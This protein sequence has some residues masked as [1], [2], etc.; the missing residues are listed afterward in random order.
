M[1][2]PFLKEYL[3]VVPDHPNTSTNRKEAQPAHISGAQPLIDAKNLTYF[4]VLLAH[5]QQTAIESDVLPINGSMMVLR[6]ENE[7][8]VRQFLHDDPYTKA[9]VWNI[10]EAQIWCFKSG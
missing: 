10:A 4:G 2:A 6:A 9:G 1:A 5:N 8:M 3:I 7:Q